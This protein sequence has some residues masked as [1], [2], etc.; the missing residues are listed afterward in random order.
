MTEN[1]SP[2]GGNLPAEPNDFIGRER[3][4]AELRS[5]LGQ[6]RLLSLCGPGGIGKTRLAV[7]LA[8]SLAGDFPHGVWLADLSEA[9]SRDRAVTLITAALGIR[10]DAGR[11]SADVLV[12][13]LRPRALLLIL[14]TCEHL[15]PDCAALARSLVAECPAI[16]IVAT[17]RQPLGIPAEAIWRVPPLG[18]PPEQPESP[19]GPQPGT[20]PAAESVLLFAAR[21][22]A[23][24]P[25]FRLDP[26]IAPAV[27]RICLALDGM[28]LAIELAAAR[29]RTLSP[30]QI[31]ARLAGRLDLLA[32][33]DR[34]APPR[35]RSLRATVAW[36]YDLL[37]APE[38]GLLRR[39]SAFRG[40]TLEM[41]TLA[42]AGSPVRPDD[43]ESVLAALIDKSLV[44]ADSAGSGLTRYKMADTVREFAADRAATASETTAARIAHRDAILAVAERRSARLADGSMPWPDRV[45]LF[46]RAL[47]ET[48]NLRLALACCA[49]L[50]HAEQGLR[51]CCAWR[52][53]WYVTR[54]SSEAAGWL[55]TFLAGSQVSAGLRSRALVTRAEF[56][57][58]RAEYDEAERFALAGLELGRAAADGNPAGA[59]RTLAM[60]ALRTGRGDQAGDLADQ[61][62]ELAEQAGDGWEWRLARTVRAAAL[63]YQ[64]SF[65]RAEGVLRQVLTE[66]GG[67][68]SWHTANVRHGLGQLA[69]ARR[70]LPEA[71]DQFRAALGIYQQVQSRPEMASCLAGL[72]Q[73]QLAGGDLDDARRSLAESLRLSL[74]AG[75]QAALPRGL[76]RMARIAA[77]AGDA[78]RAARLTGAARAL[79][80]LAGPRA[81]GAVTAGS[82]TSE[83]L[84][85]RLD[86]LAAEAATALGP[87][88]ARTLLAE[89]AAM[90]GPEAV[91]LAAADPTPGWPGP[92]TDREREVALLV[93]D[94]LSNQDIGQ[95]LF[96]S[97][98]TA[99]RHIA[100]IY[101][102]L[103]LR[104]RSQLVAWVAAGSSPD[105]P[106]ADQAG[107]R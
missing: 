65:D 71:M 19:G 82:P 45:G 44:S 7:R 15:L 34:T 92:L 70:D 83:P 22:R 55:D 58:E 54:D 49:D 56:A 38:Q 30:E 94:G 51:L 27:A 17:T 68:E 50:G 40:W 63:G 3:D 72:G 26:A 14:D 74:E 16:R 20:L 1:I 105:R 35:Q 60:T 33:G 37:T 69:L 104:T 62:A 43:A 66:S 102:K 90:D 36:S 31:G 8:A 81:A 100:N 96:I 6:V 80:R 99:A 46:H 91:A 5:M 97:P 75:Q 21:A 13:A 64:G 98:R 77:A 103:G 24:R 39:L 9:D 78:E 12:Q 76:A 32:L 73:A 4:L 42:C 95:R 61:A 93:A 28:P 89:G 101:A 47:T 87:A 10:P 11:T 86:R 18:L 84:T 23:V 57:F 53:I 67:I 41:A 79:S 85:G 59:L 2:E 88:R 29:V 52:P 106:A 48:P 25:G 107:P